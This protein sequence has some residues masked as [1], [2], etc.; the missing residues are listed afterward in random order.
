MCSDPLAPGRLPVDFFR[1]TAEE[2]GFE[3][4]HGPLNR[5]DDWQQ[6][7]QPGEKVLTANE[8]QHPARGCQSDDQQRAELAP[9]CVPQESLSIERPYQTGILCSL[10]DLIELEQ[11]LMEMASI[12]RDK[13]RFP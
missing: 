5:G 12:L 10:E 13:K 9:S 3:K 8:K 6:T 4:R 1:K 2:L 7:H 11:S